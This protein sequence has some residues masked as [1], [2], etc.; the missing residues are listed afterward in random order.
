VTTITEFSAQLKLA[1]WALMLLGF[2]GLVIVFWR[3]PR[4][5][6]FA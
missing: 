1:I 3:L 4:K 2:A 6:S 5:I